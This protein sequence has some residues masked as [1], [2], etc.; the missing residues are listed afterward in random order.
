MISHDIAIPE[1][2]RPSLPIIHRESFLLKELH[3]NQGLHTSSQIRKRNEK[4][5]IHLS[6]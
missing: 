3:R 2:E 4:Q 6:P 1:L 5:N